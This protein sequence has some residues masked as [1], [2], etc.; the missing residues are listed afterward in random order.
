LPDSFSTAP[1]ASA[2]VFKFCALGLFS[3]VPRTSFPV[4]K[5]C[6]PVVNFDGNEGV[7]SRFNVLRSRTCFLW[8]LVRQVSYS[9]FVRPDSF[10]TV[11]RAMGSVFLFCGAECVG[12]RFHVLRSGTRFRRKLGC[13]V[14][15]SCF[16][17]Q[18]SFPAVPRASGLVFKFCAPGLVIGATAGIWSRFHVLRNRTHF[19]RYRGRRHSFSCFELPNSFSTIA[20]PSAPFFKFCAPELFF[21][22]TEGVG[23]RFRQYRGRRLPYSC[24]ALP[25]SFSCFELPNTYSTVPRAS[26]PVFMFCAPGLIFGGTAGIGSRF[27]VLSCQTHFRRY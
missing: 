19:L 25:D 16:A 5:F 23:T 9:C 11:P 3:A 10:S 27:H 8:C 14:S 1:R 13:Q 6:A 12:P 17:L 24:F 18:E 22:G 4:F 21:G 7:Q 15:F 26:A 20:R 2:P